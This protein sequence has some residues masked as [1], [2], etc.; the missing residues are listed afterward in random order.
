M[1]DAGTLVNTSQNYV[2]AYT[3]SAEAF[4]GVNTLSPGMKI[5]YQ[6][7][8][9]EN[10]RANR[11]FAQLGKRQPLPAHKGKI[12]EWRKWNLLP[13]ADVLVEGVIPEGKRFGQTSQQVDLTQMGLYVTI[14]DMLENF[15]V[16]PVALGAIEE[17]GA[18]IGRSEEKLIRAA[19]QVGGSN[20]LYADQLNTG[21][22]GFPFV[23]EVTSRHKL[24]AEAATFSL[25]SPDT[26]AKGVTIFQNADAP[27]FDGAEYVMAIHPSVWY[28]LRRNPEWIDFHKYSAAQELFNGEV[29]TLHGVRFLKSTL[30]PII[31]GANLT[32]AARNLTVKTTL[33]AAGKTLAV[34]EAISTGEATALAGRK[35]LVNGTLHTVDSAEA[36]AAGAATITTVDNVTVAD[37][38]DG[39]IIYPGEGGAKGAAIFQSFLFAKDAFSIIDPDGMGKE[40]IIHDKTSG[41]GGPLNQFGTIG[42]K[43]TGAAKVLYPD[44]LLVIESTSKFSAT[45]VAN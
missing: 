28:D 43:F 42:G 1:A 27:Y 26:V 19:L 17:V 39:N 29:G 15:H 30:C 38:T 45:A 10:A 12:T 31:K 2:N 25:M 32:A 40:T 14:T 35:I 8:M 34:D 7:V 13:D 23:A 41:I 24:S 9:L 4:S 16:D 36:G 18:S 3:G 20:V 37:G 6:T 22:A 21:S 5:F 44:R 11:I 33:S